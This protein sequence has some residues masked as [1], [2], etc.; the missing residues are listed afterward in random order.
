[1]K[2][3]KKLEQKK[4][5]LDEKMTRLEERRQ[6]KLLGDKEKDAATLAKLREKH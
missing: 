5:K 2:E 3:L 1:D 6:S 4:K